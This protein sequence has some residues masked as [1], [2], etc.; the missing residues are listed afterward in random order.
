MMAE[1]TGAAVAVV[2]TLSMAPADSSGDNRG[3]ARM[4]V[5]GRNRGSSGGRQ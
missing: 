4:A 5:A 3:Q 2:A 1:G